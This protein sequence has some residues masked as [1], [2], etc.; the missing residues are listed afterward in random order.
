MGAFEFQAPKLSLP[1]SPLSVNATS[2]QGAVVSYTATASEPDD[3][4]ATPTVSCS[5]ASGSTFAIGTTTVNCSARDAATPPDITTGSFQVLIKGAAAQVSD[6]VTTVN[7]FHL[8][9]SLQTSLDNKLTDVLTALQAGQTTTACSEL[10]DFIGHV[11][12]QSGKGL[13]TSQATQ[14]IAAAKQVQAVLGC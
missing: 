11:Q 12:S 13:T 4:S 6:L 2:S 10:T 1:S 3:A 5:P 14:L 7:S 8:A 9:T